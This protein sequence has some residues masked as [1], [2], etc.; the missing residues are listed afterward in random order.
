MSGVLFYIWPHV[1]LTRMGY[2][3]E[4]LENRHK[5]LIQKN[6]VLRIEVASLKS[7][8]HIEKIARERLGLTFPSD[9]QI[10]IVVQKNN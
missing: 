1:R 5:I 4:R 10:A 6:K 2:E 9:G 8:E 3:F 7:L